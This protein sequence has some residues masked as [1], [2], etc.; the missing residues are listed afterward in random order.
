[1]ESQATIF[2]TYR[3]SI[4]FELQKEFLQAWRELTEQN[5]EKYG[6]VQ[7]TLYTLDPQ[8]FVSITE[9]PDEASWSAWKEEE[10]THP[11]REKWRPYRIAGPEQMRETIVIRSQ[12]SKEET[13]LERRIQLIEER[14]RKVELNKA[15]ETSSA[16]KGG[17]LALTYLV[18]NLLFWRIGA[19]RPWVDAIIPTLGFFLS[20]L[21]F[22]FLKKIWLVQKGG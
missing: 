11:A 2:F 10:A 20:S 8:D 12:I 6:L 22:P 21:T 18:M 5:K 19:A 1:M 4:P 16:R 7:A 15:W 13:Q 3:W 17:I 9:W 14:N